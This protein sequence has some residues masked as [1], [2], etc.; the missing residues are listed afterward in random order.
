MYR[1]ELTT[2]PRYLSDVLVLTATEFG[3][4][5]YL[6][7]GSNDRTGDTHSIKLKPLGFLIRTIN[8]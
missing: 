3:D 4:D 7:P 8:M 2:T 6:R 1:C 5:A